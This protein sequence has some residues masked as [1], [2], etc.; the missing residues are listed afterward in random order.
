M[1]LNVTFYVTFIWWRYGLYVELSLFTTNL[2]NVECS[3]Y[4]MHKSTSIFHIFI[5]FLNDFHSKTCTIMSKGFIDIMISKLLYVK[6]DEH[7]M[8]SYWQKNIHTGRFAAKGQ[9]MKLKYIH[10]SRQSLTSTAIFVVNSSFKNI[11]SF[12]FRKTYNPTF[13]WR[14]V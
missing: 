6:N 3:P 14:F 8:H 12:S 7:E 13:L 10:V 5:G 2:T 4:C 9:L 1:S 11:L